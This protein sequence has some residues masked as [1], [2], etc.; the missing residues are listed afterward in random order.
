MLTTEEIVAFLTRLNARAQRGEEFTILVDDAPEGMMVRVSLDSVL[1]REEI[2]IALEKLDLG[3]RHG[4]SEVLFTF[5]DGE[6]RKKWVT[7]KDGPDDAAIRTG[8]QRMP[9]TF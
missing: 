3:K 5:Y 6:L 7:L 4:H 1:T 8:G 9:K 2:M